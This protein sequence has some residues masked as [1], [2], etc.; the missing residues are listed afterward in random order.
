MFSTVLS[1]SIYGMKSRLVRVEADIGDGLPG[2]GMV[3]YLSAQVKEAQDRVRTAL[4]NSGYRLEPKRITV[5]LAPA[6]LK[7]SGSGFDLPIAVAIAAGYGKIPQKSLENI[8]IAGE[9]SLN[10]NVN[11]I[12]GVLPI[13]ASAAEYGCRVCMVPKANAREGAVIQNVDVIGVDSLKDAISYLE[14][15][16]KIKPVKIDPHEALIG[17]QE[18]YEDFGDIYGQEAVRR[19]AEVA[20]SG[21]HNLLL[22]GPPGSGKSMIAKRIPGIMPPMSTEEC[23]EVSKVYSV[24]GKLPAN[25]SLLLK[26]PFRSPHHTVTAKA[27]TGGG[28]I[29]HPGEISLAH[30]GV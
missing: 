20:V 17:E 19:A 12:T 8:I 15:V 22:I 18:I 28:N 9:L 2:F 3:G 14:G 21:F 23:L 6:D 11:G 24:A 1:A 30:N 25:G 27:L 13:V 5:N 7:K 10:G 16:K 29:P 26:R 4:K